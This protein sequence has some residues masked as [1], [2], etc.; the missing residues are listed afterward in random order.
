MPENV[1]NLLE[2]FASGSP[3]QDAHLSLLRAYGLVADDMYQSPVLTRA[4]MSSLGK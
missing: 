4:A 3:M 2:A 1:K